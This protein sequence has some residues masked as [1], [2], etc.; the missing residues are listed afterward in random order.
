MQCAFLTLAD[1]VVVEKDVIVHRAHK[2]V[3]FVVA[4]GEREH[5]P[6]GL[7]ERGRACPA[8]DAMC[9]HSLFQVVRPIEMMIGM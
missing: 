6:H 8:A 7:C 4:L 3:S 9:M 2:N 5:V 1:V